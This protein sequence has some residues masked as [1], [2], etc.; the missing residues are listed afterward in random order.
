LFK[1]KYIKDGEEREETKDFEGKSELYSYMR[2]ISASLVSVEE[3]KKEKKSFSLWPFGGRVKPHD[4]ISFTKNMAVMIEAGLS[5]SRA[6]AILRKQSH[7][8][9]LTKIIEDV[10][11][12]V[13]GGETLSSALSHYPKQFSKL[14]VSMV[15]AGEGSG[16]LV[17]SLRSVSSQLEK[18]YL[19]SK[20]IKGAMIYPVIVLSLMVILGILMLVYMVPTLTETFKG[21]NIELPLPTRILIWI[22]DFLRNQALILIGVVGALAASAYYS[23]RTIKGKRFKDSLV[24]HLPLISGLVKEVNSARTTRTLSSLLSS[25]VDIVV[26]IGVTQEVMQNVHYKKVLEKAAESIQSGD[27]ISKVFIEASHLYPVFVGEMAAVGE[28]TGKLGGMLENIADYYEEEVDQKTKDMSTIIEPFLMVFIGIAVAIFAIAMLAPT[29]S[30]VD[31][32]Q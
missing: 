4:I 9:R 25:G 14:F 17:E 1:Y 12:L 27:Q 2:K 24:L 11:S 32:I 6:L 30:L 22:S 28:E 18:S 20:K 3:A 16:N 26:A 5:L 15:R 10:E 7:N 31:A 29:Y 13:S 21:L 19:L 23:L 8:K